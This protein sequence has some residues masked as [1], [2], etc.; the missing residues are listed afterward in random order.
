M[1]SMRRMVAR[2][3]WR[4]LLLGLGLSLYLVCGGYTELKLTEIKPLPAWL[5]KD[6]AYHERAVTNALTGTGAY[7]DHSIGTGF[8]Y[9]PPAL[10]IV[11]LYS[12]IQPFFLKA[13]VYGVSQSALWLLMIYGVARRYGYALERVWYWFVL[14]L[15]FAPF[16]ELLH[17][18][19]INVITLFGLGLLF[20]FEDTAPSLAGAGL[21]LAVWTKVTP[22]LL[23]GYL[24][25][26]RRWK[27]LGSFLLVSLALAGLTLWRYGSPP[28][29]AYP[30][31]LGELL[32]AVLHGPNAQ[33]LVAKLGIANVPGFQA[34]V[35]RLPVFWQTPLQAGAAFCTAQPQLL[36]RGLTV[37]VA[38]LLLTSGGLM[39]AG[40]QEREPFF[41]VTLL[42]MTLAPGI[43]WYHHYVF[44]MLPI[45]VW[46]GWR[47]LAWRTVG[48][49]LIGLLIIQI[50]R[51][52]P[53]YGLL[54]HVW[55]HL[56]LVG[57]VV[58]QILEVYQT[59]RA[60]SQR[61]GVTCLT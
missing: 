3:G 46:M 28:W 56:S 15:G 36:Q 26:R 40:R 33:S 7:A 8:L 32:Q 20:I 9:P 42:G 23:V 53:P 35:T 43:M 11:E 5:L 61:S 29:L 13:A 54:I 17:I 50:D 18:G 44:L 21:S 1:P 39:L 6:L 58:H 51:R 30:A 19:Q 45:L 22:V 38:A 37:Y 12:H 27:V 31:V 49:C 59:R 24:L 41:I 14:G 34:W 57:L 25:A 47:R 2:P 48:W 55:G 52:F 10:L 16:L 60:S 4:W